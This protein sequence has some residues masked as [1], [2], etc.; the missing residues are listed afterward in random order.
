M[1]D[2]IHD[3]LDPRTAS[4]RDLERA[5][6]RGGLK[7]LRLHKRAGNPV[8]VWD[9]ETDRIVLLPPDEI[10]DEPEREPGPQSQPNPDQP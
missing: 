10:P 4:S 9:R 1:N 2:P 5:M 8:V 3:E 6:R 7:A